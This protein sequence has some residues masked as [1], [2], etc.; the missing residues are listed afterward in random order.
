MFLRQSIGWGF[1]A[2]LVAT[3]ALAQPTTRVYL[4]GEVTPVYFND[5]DTF[6]ILGGSLTGSSA[7]IAGFNTLES[8]GPVHQWGEWTA[9]ELYFNAKQATLNARRGVWHCTSDLSKDTYGRI[10]CNCHD[11]ALDQISKGLA[12]AMSI[13]EKP[14]NSE[15][16]KVQQEAIKKQVGFWAHGAPEYILTSPHSNDESGTEESYD[17]FVSTLDGHSEKS[18]HGH[19]YKPCEKVC[20]SPSAV[21]NKAADAASCMTYVGYN[22]RFGPMR[23]ECLK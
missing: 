12:H 11:L 5:G 2:L 13:D 22:N 16:I 15:L 10:L 6:K 3:F 19:V 21:K 17:R 4:N 1:V 20:Y 18:E 23:A 7:R 9:K 14:A 8:Y